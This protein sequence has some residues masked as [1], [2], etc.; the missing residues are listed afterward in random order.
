M[1]IIDQIKGLGRTGGAIALNDNEPMG[2][3]DT[4]AFFDDDGV[5]ISRNGSVTLYRVIDNSPVLFEDENDQLRPGYVIDRLLIALQKSTST[6]E[7]FLEEQSRLDRTI[8]FVT[9][10]WFD[11]PAPNTVTDISPKLEKHI[12]KTLSLAPALERRLVIGVELFPE[13]RN[14]K[15]MFT[16][17]AQEGADEIDYETFIGPYISD[18]EAVEEILKNAGTR[19]LTRNERNRFIA[20]HNHGENTD[21]PIWWGEKHAVVHSNKGKL[22]MQM[23]AVEELETRLAIPGDEFLQQSMNYIT[24][25]MPSICFIRTQLEPSRFT[26]KRAKKTVQNEQKQLMQDQQDNELPDEEIEQKYAGAYQLRQVLQGDEHPTLKETSIVYGTLARDGYKH[27]GTSFREYMENRFGAKLSPLSGQQIEGF[28]SARPGGALELNPIPNIAMKTFMSKYAKSDYSSSLLSFSGAS[29]N[30]NVGDPNG[31]VIGRN[32]PNGEP[33]YF[34]PFRT[35]KDGVSPAWLILGEPGSGKS[36]LLK[37]II[38]QANLNNTGGVFIHPKR[39]L[40][41]KTFAESEGLRFINFSPSDPESAGMLDP[42]LYLDDKRLA[43]RMLSSFLLDTL[44]SDFV[45]KEA[46]DFENSF[47][48]AANNEEVKCGW[49]TLPYMQNT[50]RFSRKEIVKTIA[51]SVNEGGPAAIVISKKS[52]SGLVFASQEKTVTIV[53]IGEEFTLD[54]DSQEPR[55]NRAL[56]KLMVV[57]A[58][59]AMRATG[60]GLFMVDEAHAFLGDPSISQLF[61][62]IVRKGRSEYIMPIFASQR[63]TDLK[64]AGFQPSR[65]TLLMTTN[66]EEARTGLK[67]AR[68]SEPYERHIEFL[69][70]CNYTPERRDADG[71]VIQEEKLPGG[72]IMDMNQRHGRITMGPHLPE[73]LSVLTDKRE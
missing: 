39:D 25:E 73:V 14:L 6:F 44:F 26:V 46:T 49:D 59:Y 43:A 29:L 3:I 30:G 60:G 16:F 17:Q 40:S 55:V 23:Y 50:E 67:L 42:F 52:E 22:K 4:L 56:L 10:Q 5:C 54:G 57:E 33:H 53:H 31:F 15:E 12:E 47:L 2:I 38:Y 62:S 37:D 65:V 66:E 1:G 8:H 69:K 48:R 32:Q 58:F 34:D 27:A 63:V 13:A 24:G 35:S 18:Y 36:H 68:M 7:G 51:S 64:D 19:R 41:L 21:I 61:S 11:E 9:L 72:I 45:G 28:A 70:N 71:N 20:W